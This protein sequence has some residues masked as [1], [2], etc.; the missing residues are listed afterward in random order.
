[1][2]AIV[3]ARPDWK[4]GLLL[5]AAV[6]VLWASGAAAGGPV[7][8]VPKTIAF[9]DSSGNNL[10][11]GMTITVDGGYY[12]VEQGTQS[13]QGYVGEGFRA[14]HKGSRL[15]ISDNSAG[16]PDTWVVQYPMT[17]GGSW[18]LYVTNNGQTQVLESYGT[19]QVTTR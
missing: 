12:V 1:M 7:K 8:A 13:L 6:G 19:Y 11:S 17:S 9:Y 18:W 2:S 16:K 10:D 4:T 3:N 15:Y 14:S 5:G